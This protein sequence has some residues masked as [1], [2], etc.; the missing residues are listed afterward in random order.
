[1]AYKNS[2]EYIN[3][4]LEDPS[5]LQSHQEESKLPSRHSSLLEQRYSILT[6]SEHDHSN[7]GISDPLKDK[8][9]YQMA[10]QKIKAMKTNGQEEE[11]GNLD[12]EKLYKVLMRDNH[13][14]HGPCSKYDS[15]LSPTFLQKMENLEE[16]FK[17][18][19]E[20]YDLIIKEKNWS[21]LC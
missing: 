1:M 3:E 14:E 12:A 5:V 8:L 21:D 4:M 2:T 18:Y 16:R 9:V 13:Y 20:W 10:Q 15:M 17:P 11:I 6:Q 19:E 7:H